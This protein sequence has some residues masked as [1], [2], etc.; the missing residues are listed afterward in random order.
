MRRD[1]FAPLLADDVTYLIGQLETWDPVWMM[2]MPY[3]AE[4][5]RAATL[6][7]L[8]FAA[9]LIS[10]PGRVSN[11]I[12]GQIRLTWWREALDEVFGE[13][14]ARRQPVVSAMKSLS[15][16]ST[17]R[18]DDFEAMAE[19]MEIFLEAA[20]D[21]S[22]SQAI[23]TRSRFFTGLSELLCEDGAPLLHGEAMA[24]YH[25]TK[26]AHSPVSPKSPEGHET[27]TARFAR[28]AAERAPLIQELSC[29]LREAKGNIDVG[30]LPPPVSLPLALVDTN[31]DN[32]RLI[33]NPL[34][35]RWCLFRSVLTGRLT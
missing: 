35:Q 23:E 16:R 32:A 15:K 22:V 30:S 29:R 34:A 26:A 18:R 17:W 28:A 31:T 20:D 3:V 27:P 1:Q 9:E 10:I 12:L 8:A 24:L 33:Q 21:T 5:K 7:A 6:T 14:S 2:V 11:P 4:G 19:S 25:L 13:G